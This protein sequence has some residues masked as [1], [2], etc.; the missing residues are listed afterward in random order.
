MHGEVSEFWEA[1]RAG[2][3]R[4]PC[5]KAEKMVALGLDPL[6]CG[7]EELADIVIRAFDAAEALG[8]DIGRA[9]RV[10]HEFNKSRP[11]KHGGKLA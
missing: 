5:D 4:K 10:K 2:A 8:F 9:V 11:F 3:L 1:Y 6:T 7:E